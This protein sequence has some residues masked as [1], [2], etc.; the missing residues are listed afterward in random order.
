MVSLDSDLYRAHPDWILGRGQQAVGRNQYVLD[1]SREEVQDHLITVLTELFSSA[2]ISYVKWD[3]NRILT[4]SCSSALPPQRQG[5]V[6][7]R[8]VLGLYRVLS[9]LTER[10]P[11]ILFEACASGGNR[12]DPGMLCYMPQVWLSDNTDALCRSRMQHNASYGYPQSVMGAHVSG[13]P[14]HQTLRQTSLDSRFQVAAMGLLGYECNLCELTSGEKI[15]I[16]AQI[17][18]YKK[19]RD[20]L[21]FGQLYRLRHGGEGFWQLMAVSPDQHTALTLLFQ[22]ENH[23]NAPALRLLARGLDSEG[24]YRLSVRPVKVD[25]RQ[26][27]GLV[28]MISPVHIRQGSLVELAAARFMDLKSEQEDLVCDG[29]TL[30]A[31]GA[32]IKQSFSGTGFDDQTRVMGDCGSRLYLLERE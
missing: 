6:R 11:H 30:M 9:A 23:P 12:T 15:R 5:E 16:A 22:Q 19:Y 29:G 4:D 24:V 28:N 2:D 17:A 20:T 14:N 27:G 1:L 31:C 10:F 18:F 21:Q 7:H 32:Y 8:Y 13:S 25:M 26:F 3:M